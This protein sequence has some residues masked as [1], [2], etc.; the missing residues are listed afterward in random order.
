M[1]KSKMS[2][3]KLGW[4]ALISLVIVLILRYGIISRLMTAEIV[5]VVA[6]INQNIKCV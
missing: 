1:Q 2:A 4:G 3:G 5:K 6:G